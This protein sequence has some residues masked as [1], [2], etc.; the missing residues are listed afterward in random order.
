MKNRF[1][2]GT[3]FM[4]VLISVLV[5]SLADL[6]LLSFF[7]N[8]PKHKDINTITNAMKNPIELFNVAQHVSLFKPLQ[9]AAVLG[10]IFL[11]VKIYKLISGNGYKE[12]S[13]YGAHGTARF[14]NHSEIFNDKN[15]VKNTFNKSAKE[16]L[17]NTPG[18]ILGLIKNKPLIL[19]EKT[20]VPNR[21][22]F[23][24][25]SPGSGKTLSYILPN[26]I[27]ERN[28]SMVISDPKG[29]I[30]EA[31]AKVKKQQGYEVRLINF[32]EMLISD[33]YN[34]IDY[35]TKEIEA[36]QVANTI[37]INSMQGQKPDFWTKAEIALL[38][39]LL[40][41]V[42]YETPTDANLAN[43]KRILTTHGSTPQR[44]DQFFSH[45]DPDHPAFSA[46]Q[47]V[48]MAS[49]KVR[50][51]I[52]VSLAITLSK[53]DAKD[54]RR[55]TETS[56]FL[57]DDIGRKK[58]IVYI[59]LPVA[60]STWEPLTANFFTQMFQR[61]YDVADKNFNRL[62]VQVNLLL[63][64]FPNLGKIPGYEEILATCRSY[65][66]SSSTIVQSMGQLIDK[67]NKE[68]AEAIFNN[69]SLRYM[70]GVG[71]KLTA[72]YF[73]DL[74]GK[75]TIQT[76]SSSISKNSKGGSDSKSNNY[77]G[78]NLRTIDELTR[79][80]RD[81]AIL[82]VS[83]GY[84]IQVKKAYQHLFFKGILNDD[85]KMSRFDY[86]NLTNK[87]PISQGNKT[88]L[89]KDHKYDEKVNEKGKDF[90]LGQPNKNIEETSSIVNNLNNQN[91]EV[92][93]DVMREI[94]H[95]ETFN[96]DLVKNMD[97]VKELVTASIK[98]TD[99][100]IQSFDNKL[101]SLEEKESAIQQNEQQEEGF[102]IPLE[103]DEDE[104]ILNMIP[105][106]ELLS[107][108][109]Q[110]EFEKELSHNKDELEHLEKKEEKIPFTLDL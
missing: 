104:L 103:L 10:V 53:F 52:F 7:I 102:I 109:L 28:R 69:C 61:L 101:V 2:K 24:V 88:N 62:P 81:E 107:S 68:K 35:I 27:F 42:K 3:V 32:K 110:A 8:F 80:P 99:S 85:N 59:I 93:P 54:V 34:P 86:F 73:S 18:L 45:L 87:V 4:S 90:A 98:D 16:N 29:E 108:S 20:K 19:P 74:I 65:G 56:D 26:I 22:V 64:E 89:A 21:N 78:R 48:R 47:I 70:L 92:T 33:R 96:D 49:D 57:L 23:I 67:Y 94:L 60:D 13:E 79:M 41:Y 31:T 14:S 15:F 76:Q 105:E 83:G 50:D 95:S 77:T 39:T 12:A 100:L 84:P 11:S 82:L 46:Y 75:T 9:L 51:S 36:E 55:F 91:K 66:I 37:V 97:N 71:D 6:F 5:V 106:E 72:E 58:M 63:D 30:F 38:K 43:V 44:M 25:G 17:K 40:L 1:D